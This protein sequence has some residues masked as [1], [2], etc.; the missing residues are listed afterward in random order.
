[1]QIAAA[2]AHTAARA[3]YRDSKRADIRNWMAVALRQG[4][5]RSAPGTV[6]CPTPPSHATQ[7]ER[8]AW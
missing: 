8:A 3:E 6:T 2:E 1:V 7:P 5:A 4:I